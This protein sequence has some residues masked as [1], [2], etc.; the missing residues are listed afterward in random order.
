MRRLLTLIILLL[1]FNVSKSQ[2]CIIAYKSDKDVYIG[3][4]SR[5]S[6]SDLK[7]RKTTYEDTAC[8][9]RLV[10]GYYF[11]NEG[12][13]P[14]TVIRVMSKSL[15]QGKTLEQAI[16][17]FGNEIKPILLDSINEIAKLDSNLFR[18]HL[19]GFPVSLF[20]AFFQNDTPMLL[21]ITLRPYLQDGKTKILVGM[22]R[23]IKEVIGSHTKIDHYFSDGSPWTGDIASKIEQL[24][25]IESKA[26]S[27][28]GL[29]VDILKIQKTGHTW[30]KRKQYCRL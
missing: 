25:T 15:Q 8:K 17:L 20:V 30:I 18:A 16:R 27:S 14:T 12:F 24:I 5:V 11:A 9:I 4:D 23:I 3:A 10:N 6:T 28:V 1:L 26:D 22:G 2:T 19:R 13:I 7:T 21:L 29:P